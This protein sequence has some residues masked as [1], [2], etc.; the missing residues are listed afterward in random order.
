M[1]RYMGNGNKEENAGLEGSV[2]ADVIHY[3][4]TV[5]MPEG[6]DMWD[7]A[8]SFLLSFSS[9]FCPYLHMA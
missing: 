5:P 9:S 2:S 6:W 8:L 7:R 1:G 4:I 3:T